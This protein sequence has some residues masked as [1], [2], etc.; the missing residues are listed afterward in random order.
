M[1]TDE[2]LVTKYMD[3]VAHRKHKRPE[4][5]QGYIDRALIPTIGTQKAHDVTPW[6]S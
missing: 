4:L 6:H 5:A 1:F 3:E 2:Q